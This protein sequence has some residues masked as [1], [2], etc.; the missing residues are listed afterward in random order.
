MRSATTPRIWGKPS[1]RS[2]TSSPQLAHDSRTVFA[3][4]S[5]TNARTTVGPEMSASETLNI[6]KF[7]YGA[8]DASRHCWQWQVSWT[9]GAREALNLKRPQLHDATKGEVIGFGCEVNLFQGAYRA[10]QPDTP[11]VLSGVSGCSCSQSRRAAPVRQVARP[12]AQ[13]PLRCCRIMCRP[14]PISSAM[15]HQPIALG[16]VPQTT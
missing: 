2:R 6:A 5:A 1:V 9:T 3:P 13:E 12:R 16:S 11:S 8:P 4:E 7:V 14:A 15:P 10:A